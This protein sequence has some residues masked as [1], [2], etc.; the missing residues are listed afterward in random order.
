MVLFK[1]KFRLHMWRCFNCKGYAYIHDG[2]VQ[3]VPIIQIQ[4]FVS[5][6]GKLCR[7]LHSTVSCCS[8]GPQ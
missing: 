5:H 3:E 8:S 2:M 7:T 6:R 4:R 1:Y